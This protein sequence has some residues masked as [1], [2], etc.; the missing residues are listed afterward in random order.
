MKKDKTDFINMAIAFDNKNESSDGDFLDNL[1]SLLYQAYEEGY[2]DGVKDEY[3][4]E[5]RM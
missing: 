2:S 3:Q 5:G 4:G 1:A